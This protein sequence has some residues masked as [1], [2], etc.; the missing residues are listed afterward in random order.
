LDKFYLKKEKGKAKTEANIVESVAAN[1][2]LPIPMEGI[3]ISSTMAPQNEVIGKETSCIESYDSSVITTLM[4]HCNCLTLQEMAHT[5]IC[6]EPT[7][8]SSACSRLPFPIG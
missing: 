5:V 2:T 7:A 4:H 8:S 6:G 1:P 3:E